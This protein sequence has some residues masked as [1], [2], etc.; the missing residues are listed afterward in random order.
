MRCGGLVRPGARQPSPERK[1]T[2]AI[3]AGEG[4]HDCEARQRH[5]SA[6][7]SPGQP[8]GAEHR[9]GDQWRN[10]PRGVVV[11]D[12]GLGVRG[13]EQVERELGN[14]G[15]QDERRSRKEKCE[16]KQKLG[17]IADALPVEGGRHQPVRAGEEGLENPSRRASDLFVPPV[18]LR[19]GSVVEVRQDELDRDDCDDNAGCGD[20]AAGS[21][22]SPREGVPDAHSRDHERDLFL[23]QRGQYG[24]G[25]ERKEAVLVEVPEGIEQKWA[26]ERDGMEL[27]QGQPL[28]GRI[29]QVGKREA[30]GGALRANVLAGE[31][32]DRQRA[33]RDGDGLH[34]EE[35]ARARPDPPE[36]REKDEDRVDVR[37]EPRDLFSLEV[38]HRQ[39]VPVRCCPD[40]LRHVPE[41]EPSGVERVVA[42]DGEGAEA[43]RVGRHCDPQEP[44]R[45]R[46]QEGL[47]KCG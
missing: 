14:G 35:H 30:E 43:A 29:E 41:V 28:H 31:P 27:V 3:V 26:R 37:A 22:L 12:L 33:E 36:R 25:G 11:V 16:R 40:G 9:G 32:E 23:R 44:L 39:R 24:E 15:D 20:R 10:E 47:A 7:I 17:E 42:K 2:K 5:A 45:P 19:G 18:E 46:E 6:A 13:R 1:G 4:H 21:E 38:R 8:A 34:G